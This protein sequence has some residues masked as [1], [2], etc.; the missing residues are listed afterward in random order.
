MEFKIAWEISIDAANP[1]EA[2]KL[3]TEMMR[4]KGSEWQFYV[5]E[6]ESNDIFS[7]DLEEE[8]EDAVLLVNGNYVPT[9]NI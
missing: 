5:Q 4:D 7:V 2:A 9:I 3:A 1:L 6:D 8:D